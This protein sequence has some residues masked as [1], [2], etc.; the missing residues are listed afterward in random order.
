MEKENEGPIGK[1]RIF[2]NPKKQQYAVMSKTTK[3]DFIVFGE[4]RESKTETIM[5]LLEEIVKAYGMVPI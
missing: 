4:I 5:E 2:Y 3:G 1:F